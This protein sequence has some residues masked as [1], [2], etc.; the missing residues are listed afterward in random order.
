MGDGH[1]NIDFFLPCEAKYFHA[2]NDESN[3]V[4]T[5]LRK[6]YSKGENNK[7]LPQPACLK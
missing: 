3:S 5:W 1:Q 7:Q 6:N 4:G 2:L